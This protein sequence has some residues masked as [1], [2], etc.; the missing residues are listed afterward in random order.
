MLELW[1]YDETSD[2]EYGHLKEKKL[3]VAVKLSASAV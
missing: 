2:D 3:C 1:R